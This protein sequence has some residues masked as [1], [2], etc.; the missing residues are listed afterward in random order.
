M[1]VFVL[2][3]VS[4]QHP[5]VGLLVAI[6]SHRHQRQLFLIILIINYPVILMQLVSDWAEFVF[7]NDIMLEKQENN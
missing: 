6:I 5:V 4:V 1:S 7:V 3:C 2:V